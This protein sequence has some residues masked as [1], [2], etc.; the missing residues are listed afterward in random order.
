M[1]RAILLSILLFLL[2]T[3]GFLAGYLV[4]GEF[5]VS[6]HERFPILQQAY[7]IILNHGYQEMP[8]DRS[9]EYGMIRG[10]LQEYAD[11]YSIFV[12]PAQHELE[13]NNLQGNFGGIGVDL[14]KNDDG[15]VIL[16]PY[17][18]SPA[19]KAGI[20]NG[21]QLFVVDGLIINPE[22]PL[23]SIQAAIRGT[24]G[25][26][27]SLTIGRSPDFSPI[28]IEVI[29]E[30]Y[31]LPS[32]A[33]HIH[34]Q[35]SRLGIVKVNL[36]ADSTPEEISDAFKKLLD[37]GA[38]HF[39]LDLRNN[40]GGLLSAGIDT[41]KLFL[42]DGQILQQQYKGEEIESIY[43]DKPGELRNVPLAV[44]INHNTASAAEII[45]GALKQNN[46]AWLIGES[47]F[48]KDSIQLIFDLDDG[49]SLHITSAKW[50]IPGLNPVVG[51]NGIQPDMHLTDDGDNPDSMID[52]ARGNFFP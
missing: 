38:T 42:Q 8:S 23:N 4:R 36:I 19:E 50:W 47:T 26:P 43:V 3:I 6:N 5:N 17:P 48:G 11:P 45:A 31:Q 51:G 49:S 7:E 15:I 30:L 22:T 10:M 40:S 32:T 34:P 46:R 52:A 21:D 20:L 44:L 27:V 35:E 29:R 9:F 33:A 1:K 39:I 37:Q 28:N 12:E 14:Y 2:L 16:N 13:S 18:G 41:A 25:E 24:E